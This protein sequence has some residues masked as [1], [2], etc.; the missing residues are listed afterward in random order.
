M[1]DN[2]YTIQLAPTLSAHW[3]E[4]RDKRTGRK[5]GTFPSST[6]ILNAYPQSPHLTRWIAENGWQE[7]QR[8]KSE[9][10]ERGTRVHHAIEALLDG[11]EL[12]R[13]DYVLEEWYKI[14]AFTRWYDAYKP[15]D[16]A[17]EVAVF[18]KKGKY[19]GRV[20]RIMRINGELYVIDFKTSNSLH[21]HFPLQFASYANAIEETLGLTVDNT[22]A[23]QLGASNKNTYRFVIQP[24]AEWRENYKVFQH[25]RNVWEYEFGAKAQEPPILTLPDTLKIL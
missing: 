25:V 21:A 23:I 12:A 2:P 5:V 22:A 8:I 1:I 19:A 6:T 20:D 15:E 9:A 14:T 24:R 13:T 18:S 16:I 11:Q 10:G 3:Y 4:V 17:G 7:S